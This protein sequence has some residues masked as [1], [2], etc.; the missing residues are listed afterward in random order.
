MF[1]LAGTTEAQGGMTTRSGTFDQNA[2]M[3][4][5]NGGRSGNEEI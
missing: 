4:G 2:S 1:A 3:F 5:L